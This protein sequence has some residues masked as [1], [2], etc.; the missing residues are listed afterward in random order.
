MRIT[1]SSL[2]EFFKVQAILIAFSVIVAG[3]FW[4]IGENINPLTILVYSLSLGNL[5]RIPLERAHPLYL[6]RPFPY[7]WL[8]FLSLLVPLLLPIYLISS[9]LAWWLA[10]P[11]PDTLAHYLR[12]GWKFPILITVVFSIGVF[13]Y[14]TSRKRFER[15]NREL[16]QSVERESA[17]VEIQ[18]EELQ[19]A[20]EIQE[21]LLPKQI[22]Q[23]DG[24]QISASWRPAREVSGDYF[25][26]FRLGDHSV[27]FCVADVVGKGV[28]AA[29]LMANVQ[30]AVRAFSSEFLS[31]AQVCAKVNHLLCENV[32][33]GKF[34][35]MLFGVL[36]CHLHRITYCNAGHPGPILL[37]NGHAAALDSS[38]A[39]LGVFSN[40]DYCDTS[41]SL[42]AGD[43]LLIFTDGLTEAEAGDGDEFGEFRITQT[44]EK[45]A[46]RPAAELSNALLAQV[47][48]FCH[49]R[50][51]DDATLLVLAA[52]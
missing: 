38:G 22:P 33:T 49:S 17:K 45:N 43:R 51:Q 44:V 46:S 18:K 30:A 1:R 9:T 27:A 24:F 47:D 28:S 31:P 40:W 16:Q 50:F 35:T 34:V 10:R 8:V 20:R 41:V 32:A 36:D 42:R 15:R 23:L 2:T 13:L 25:D 6:E 4:A 3:I 7:N 52:D 5:T 12:T 26:V 19:R 21:G 39:V 48:T 11:S 14:E 37:S 29:L